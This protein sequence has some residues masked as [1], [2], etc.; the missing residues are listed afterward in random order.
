MGDENPN[1]P[2]MNEGNPNAP[3]MNE[4]DPNAPYMDEASF[5]LPTIDNIFKNLMNCPEVLVSFINDVVPMEIRGEEVTEISYLPNDQPAEPPDGKGLIYDVHSVAQNGRKYIVEMQRRATPGFVNRTQI[6]VAR[7][8]SRQHVVP[9][10]F[11]NLKNVTLIV[12]ADFGGFPDDK[13]I[14]YISIHK[15]EESVTRLNLFNGMSYVFVNLKKLKIKSVKEIKTPTQGWIYFFRQKK[16][17]R[18]KDFKDIIDG[19]WGVQIIFEKLKGLT[20]S[21][22]QKIRYEASLKRKQDAKN[23]RKLDKAKRMADGNEMALAD[24]IK[25]GFAD[26]NEK[27]KAEGIKKGLADGN[28]KGLADGIKIGKA[29]EKYVLARNLLNEGVPDKIITTA[30]GLVQEI[31]NMLRVV[32]RINPIDISS[33]PTMV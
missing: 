21:E 6:Y 31:L 7:C 17:I 18:S 25:I 29:E 13:R 19:N 8:H 16:P 27:G 33:F 2:Y 32:N 28:E 24:A 15:T 4:E 20:L 1:V 22:E 9:L 12:I 14:G 11:E 23:T 26:G 3:H 10:D 5:K 30:T